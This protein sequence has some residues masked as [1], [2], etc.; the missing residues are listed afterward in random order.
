MNPE[1]VVGVGALGGRLDGVFGDWAA[2]ACLGPFA[3]VWTLGAGGR[4]ILGAE[5]GFEMAVAIS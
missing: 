2:P 5:G 1:A 3:P 4:F